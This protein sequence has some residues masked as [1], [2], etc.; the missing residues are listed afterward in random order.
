VANDIA[1]L[2][3]LAPLSLALIWCEGGKGVKVLSGLSNAGLTNLFVHVISIDPIT[4][5]TLYAGTS[6]SGVFKSMD[7]GATWSPSNSGLTSLLVSAIV[8]DPTAPATLYAG[9]SG[10]GVFKSTDGAAT[11]NAANSGLP[12]LFVN[13]LAIDPTDPNTLY[14]GANDGFIGDG[15]VFVFQSGGVFKSTNGG[16]NWI[17]LTS[18]M[19]DEVVGSFAIDPS[20]P[21]T[22]YAGLRFLPP[23]GF[24]S[25]RGGVSKSTDGGANWSDA[26]SGLPRSAWCAHGQC[27]TVPATVNALAI[28]PANPA[29]LFASPIAGGVFKSTDASANWNQSS[30]GLPA[31][32]VRSLAVNPLTPTT[33][34]AGTAGDGV[35]KSTDGGATWQPTGQ[36]E[37]PGLIEK[38]ENPLLTLN[39]CGVDRTGRVHVGGRV[40]VDATMGESVFVSRGNR[41][42]S[43]GLVLGDG[44]FEGTSGPAFAQAGH[45]IT[46]AVHFPAGKISLLSTCRLRS[47]A[48]ARR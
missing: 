34:Y 21:T 17:A 13:A 4:P 38:Q 1:L 42:Q 47:S 11:W 19:E 40:G 7:G 12:R 9:T 10:G 39:I 14:A 25:T 28:D 23:V 20:N 5:S 30:S 36:G 18:G 32:A 8:V 35:Y 48:G 44:S 26:S 41:N 6:G 31:I 15:E 46:V 27:G 2:G 3:V 22:I 33:L 37:E 43:V 16:A 29:T 24:P 45:R